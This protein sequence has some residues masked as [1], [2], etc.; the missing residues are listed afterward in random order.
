MV[1]VEARTAELRQGTRM[2]INGPPRVQ[3]R[4]FLQP[5]GE[6]YPIR[7]VFADDL[8]I[9]F[10]GPWSLEENERN[11]QRIRALFHTALRVV[12]D[13]GYDVGPEYAG[14][15]IFNKRLKTGAAAFRRAGSEDDQFFSSHIHSLKSGS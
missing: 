15:R 5:P 8:L 14:A 11:A 13:Y 1:P 10:R 2:D 3:P 12:R 4:S 7:S 6:T 9:G